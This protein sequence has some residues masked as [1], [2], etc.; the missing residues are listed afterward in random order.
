[1]DARALG[2]PCRA[3]QRLLLPHDRRR[4]DTRRRRHARRR[5]A[6]AR[7]RRARDIFRLARDGKLLRRLRRPAVKAQRSG[8]GRRRPIPSRIAA[9]E[10]SMR[11]ELF[12]MAGFVVAS[13]ASAQQR[14]L[15]PD[16]RLAATGQVTEFALPRPS[17]GP[18][19]IALAADGTV[20]FTQ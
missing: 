4:R 16:E 5:R 2:Q 7:R 1:M 17:S 19:T 6:C 10:V 13:L 8:S 20:W 14:W 11:R 18:T 3:E 12:V 9:I 15:G